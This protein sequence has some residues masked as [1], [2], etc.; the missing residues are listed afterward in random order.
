MQLKLEF[1]ITDRDIHDS[2][3]RY[4]KENYDTEI[5]KYTSKAMKLKP[6]AHQ[7]TE[8]GDTMN[9]QDK[10]CGTC[11]NFYLLGKS[12]QIGYCAWNPNTVP[13]WFS[14]IEKESCLDIVKPN[15]GVNCPTWEQDL[16]LIVHRHKE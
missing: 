12:G 11:G 14:R 16:D 7:H 6:K 8:Q 10:R 13:F 3:M 1:E 15:M 5:V 2:L 9:N 4:L